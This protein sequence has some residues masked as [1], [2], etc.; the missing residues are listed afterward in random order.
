METNFPQTGA[1]YC[2]M[3]SVRSRHYYAALSVNMYAYQ[4]RFRTTVVTVIYI[5]TGNLVFPIPIQDVSIICS[6]LC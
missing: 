3:C 1:Y 5:V 2:V 4:C 6:S